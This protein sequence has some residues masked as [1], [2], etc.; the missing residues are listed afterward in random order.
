MRIKLLFDM[1]GPPYI[2][3]QTWTF[4]AERRLSQRTH[5][6]LNSVLN[7]HWSPAPSCPGGR[8]P[9]LKRWKRLKRRKAATCWT[10][11][12]DWMNTFRRPL[13]RPSIRLNSNRSSD[14]NLSFKAHLWTDLTK[15]H[16]T[17]VFVVFGN[18]QNKRPHSPGSQRASEWSY[19][20]PRKQG[21]S[22]PEG[23]HSKSKGF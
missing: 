23:F 9:S 4:P 7:T 8:R 10:V 15:S 20:E 14:T 5:L 13:Q 17:R 3:P 18:G 6:R 21:G 11:G 12:A 22:R 2:L 1:S 16:P 19:R